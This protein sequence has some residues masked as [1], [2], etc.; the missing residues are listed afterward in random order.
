MRKFILI[1]SAAALVLTGCV[2]VPTQL[3]GDYQP[4]TP[5]QA[6]TQ[7]ATGQRVRWGGEIIKVEPKPDAT[8][9]EVL[10]RELYPDARP[11]RRDASGGRF[12]ACKQGFFDPAVYTK[13]RDVTIVGSVTG[14]EQHAVGDFNY[15]FAR[16]DANEIFM[17]PKRNA[18]DSYPYYG[19]Y[20][21]GFYDPFWSP[22]YY[23]P[24]IVIVHRHH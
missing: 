17:W 21:P 12:I 2:S 4:I 11:D 13:G 18:A 9:F 10:S 7:N 3:A 6:A 24:P 22:W 20:G 15:T 14:T 5:Q 19:P 8:C 1:G 16:V 23:T